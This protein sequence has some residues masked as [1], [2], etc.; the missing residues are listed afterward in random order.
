MYSGDSE[1]LAPSGDAGGLFWD[2]KEGWSKVFHFEGKEYPSEI[3]DGLPALTVA[4]KLDGEKW[5]SV[6]VKTTSTGWDLAADRIHGLHGYPR[7]HGRRRIRAKDH[8]QCEGCCA[9]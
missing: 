1:A 5:T 2:M 3:M 8:Q 4:W 7:D 6:E 9:Q